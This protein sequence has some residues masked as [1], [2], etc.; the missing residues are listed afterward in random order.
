M[1]SDVGDLEEQR[2]VGVEACADEVLHDLRLAVDHDRAAAG[3][4]AERHA[5]PLSVELDLDAVVDEPL[6]SEAFA[7]ADVD[8]EVDRSLLEDAGPHPVLDVV[9]VSVLEHDRLDSFAMQQ[10]GEREPRGPRA[11]DPDLRAHQ[12]DSSG[13][14]SA[15]TRWAIANAPFAAGTPQ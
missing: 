4:L 12:V 5:V 14:V 10:L 3:Q 11:H 15:S 8:E 2:Q 9:A 6:P 13:S 7:D 1:D